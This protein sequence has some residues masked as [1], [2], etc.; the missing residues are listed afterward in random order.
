MRQAYELVAER[1]G[2]L[3]VICRRQADDIAHILPRGR[4]PELKADER[5]LVA[6][7]RDH[8]TATENLEGRRQ[9]LKLMERYYTYDWNKEPWGEYKS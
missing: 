1:D 8:H 9:L 3:C 6:L 4:F 5:N 7:C 2:G